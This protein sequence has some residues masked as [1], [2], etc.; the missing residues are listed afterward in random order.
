MTNTDAPDQVVVGGVVLAIRAGD[1]WIVRLPAQ[2]T[3]T[4]LRAVNKALGAARFRQAKGYVFLDGQPIYG[5]V[6]IPIAVAP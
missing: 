4:D 3:A 1:E 2:P 6:R 5:D